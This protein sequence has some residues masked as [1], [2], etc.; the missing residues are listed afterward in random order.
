MSHTERAQITTLHS[1]DPLFRLVAID[2]S[3]IYQYFLHRRV[4]TANWCSCVHNRLLSRTWHGDWALLDQVSRNLSPRATH[5][6]QVWGVKNEQFSCS[7]VSVY[8][9]LHDAKL[10]VPFGDEMKRPEAEAAPRCWSCGPG[11][12]TP[13]EPTLVPAPLERLASPQVPT[14]ASADKT[15]KNA[16]G[17]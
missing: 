4:N 7:R 12:P 2:V 15:D 9:P 13:R 3:P 10:F 14:T 8:R 5:A 17:G 11:R 16:C 6:R 1:M